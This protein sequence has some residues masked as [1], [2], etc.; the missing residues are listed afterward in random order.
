M[1]E[2]YEDIKFILCEITPRGDARGEEVIEINRII[3]RY[4]Q[5]K[6]Y[7]FL[8][9]HSNL[10]TEDKRHFSDNKHISLHAA[11]I[12]VSNIK[13]SLRQA[14]GIIKP[15]GRSSNN[16]DPQNR[17][18]MN[19]YNQNE[20]ADLANIKIEVRNIL[21]TNQLLMRGIRE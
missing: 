5:D 19:Q 21:S 10:R 1:R 8:T 2:K 17:R 12:F 9:K 16:Y 15:N 11:P 6:T 3:A 20:N 4:T 18:T 7:I 13:K 14:Y